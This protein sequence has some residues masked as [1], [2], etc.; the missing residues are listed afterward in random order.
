MQSKHVDLT[1]HDNLKLP[2]GRSCWTLRKNALLKELLALGVP[3]NGAMNKPQLLDA[4][5]A[6]PKAPEPV[7][8]Y[9]GA[10]HYGAGH[11]GSKGQGNG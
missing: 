7:K 1:E 9:G 5:A 8:F 6:H 4:Y 2:D 10:A 11:F 3:V